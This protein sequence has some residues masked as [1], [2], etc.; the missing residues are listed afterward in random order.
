MVTFLSG[1]TLLSLPRLIQ[2]PCPPPHLGSPSGCPDLWPGL[3]H[4]FSTCSLLVLFHPVSLL[5]DTG[6]PRV[7]CPS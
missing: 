2:S 5:S 4:A 1:V 6:G 7:L 3:T